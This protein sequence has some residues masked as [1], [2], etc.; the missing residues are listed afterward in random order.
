MKEGKENE[1]RALLALFKEF[2]VDY[3]ANSLSKVLNMT[4]MGALKI[5]KRMEK[6]D[7]I[8]PRQMGKAVFYSIDFNNDY[9]RTYLK[10]ALQREAEQSSP[11]VKRWVEELR[12]FKGVADIGLLF[13]SVMTKQDFND[14]DLLLVFEKARAGKVNSLLKDISDVSVKKIHLVRQTRTDIESNLKKKDKVLL[15][16]LKRG[17]VLFGYDELIEVVASVSRR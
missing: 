1:A 14:V 7:I 9:A 11:R 10:F 3:N 13:G 5:L 8:I 4:S 12:K 17:I 6:G 15:S 2:S 16:A